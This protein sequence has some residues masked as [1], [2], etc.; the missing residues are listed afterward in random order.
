MN[1]GDGMILWGAG[2]VA[3]AT[4]AVIDIHQVEVS[5]M[6]VYTTPALRD[7]LEKGIFPRWRD[8]GGLRPEPVYVA[9]GEQYNRLRMSGSRPEAD[10]FLHASPL[11]IAKGVEEGYFLPLQPRLQKEIR[12]MHHAPTNNGSAAWYAFAWSPLVEVYNPHLPERPDL[13]QSKLRFG[14]AHPT[15][16][17]N[18]IYT[19]LFFEEVSPET[20]QAVLRQTVVQPVNARTNI[21]GVADGSFDATLGYEAVAR[22]FQAQGARIKVAAP[23]LD[24]KEVSTPVLF[25]VGLVHGPHQEEARRFVDFLFRN[26]T[27]SLLSRYHF[28]SVYNLTFEDSELPDDLRYL[29]IDWGDWHRIEAILPRY[30]VGRAHG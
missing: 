25:T 15:L 2:L 9:A 3:L 18:G 20:G 14:L 10:L 6:T 12:E 23:L 13:A 5:S 17:N 21:L 4:L 1:P 24:G 8:E 22:F 28:R 11:Y 26:E 19:A 16:S 30:E 7:L 27:Q 29:S